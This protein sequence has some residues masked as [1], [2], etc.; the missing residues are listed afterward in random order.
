MLFAIPAN[1]DPT[2]GLPRLGEWMVWGP[3]GVFFGAFLLLAITWFFAISLPGAKKKQVRED[4]SAKAV[5]E[6]MRTVS[7]ATRKLAV[8]HRQS[9][10]LLETV[11]EEQRTHRTLLQELADAFAS[12]T[13]QSP[14]TS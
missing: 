1:I 14:K 6:T 3:A 13:C 9:T 4:E 5:N 2:H 12:R 11:V 7:S 8:S 10:K